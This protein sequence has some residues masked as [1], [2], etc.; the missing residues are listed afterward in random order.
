MRYVKHPADLIDSIRNG[1][2]IP[3]I[4]AGLSIPCGGISWEQLLKQMIKELNTELGHE[5][6]MQEVLM[7]LRSSVS[8][9]LGLLD[10][11][12]SIFLKL[13]DPLMIA[14]IYKDCFGTR[15]LI[16]VL[17]E[18]CNNIT[19]PG[20]A[21]NLLVSLGYHFYVTTNYD[22]LIEQAIT[23][24]GSVVQSIVKEEDVAYWRSREICVVKMHGSIINPFEP[25]SIVISRSDYEAYSLKH[26]NVDMMVQFLMTTGTLLLLG[27][28][29]RDPNFFAL[30]NRV[31]Y[32]L[33][34]HN[35]QAYFITFDLPEII[36]DYWAKYNL[37]PVSLDGRDKQASLL[38]WL[39]ELT[40]L[41]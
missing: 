6:L 27:Y 25:D 13:H 9:R 1:Q 20:Q 29:V 37:Y 24:T 41:V 28:S 11:V 18:I 2:L 36:Q 35:R 15:R 19:G 5:I 12:E 7:C 33:K 32:Y 17:R 10:D 26:P 14:Q 23:N 21:H 30:H 4:G 34:E 8:P 16:S 22:D 39:T 38:G 40:S 3:F 31:R